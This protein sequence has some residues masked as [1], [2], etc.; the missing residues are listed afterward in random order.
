MRSGMQDLLNR[1]YSASFSKVSLYFLK[2]LKQILILPIFSMS[3]WLYSSV[4][5]ATD[6]RVERNYSLERQPMFRIMVSMVIPEPVE[7]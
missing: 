7:Q 2:T 3:S 6:S 4:F 5:S 1:V